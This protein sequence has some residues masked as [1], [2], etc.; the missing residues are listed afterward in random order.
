[1]VNK[2]KISVIIP[3]YN[4]GIYLEECINSVLNQTIEDIEII[5]IDDCSR[6]KSRNILQLFQSR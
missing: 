1:M 5:I 2:V 6:D 3:N 4:N